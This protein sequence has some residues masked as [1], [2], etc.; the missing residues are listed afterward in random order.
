MEKKWKQ[1]ERLVAAI[2]HALNQTN[3]RIEWGDRID[4]REFD[5]T[6]RFSYF[7]YSYLTVVECKDYLVPV[8]EV[9]AFVTKARRAHANKA[10]MVSSVGFQSGAIKVARD[11]GIELFV[12]KESNKWPDWVKIIGEQPAIGIEQVALYSS[13]HCHVFPNSSSALTYYTNHTILINN[14]K[15]QTTLNEFI[16]SQRMYWEKHVSTKPTTIRLDIPPITVVDMPFVVRF[17][18][19]HV[20]FQAQ[21]INTLILETGGVDPEMVPALFSFTDIITGKEHVVSEGEIWIGFDTVIQEG[22]FYNDPLRGQNFYCEKRTGNCI[23]VVLV[24]S[25]QHGDLFQCTYDQT[26]TGPSR[27]LEVTDPNEIQRLLKMYDLYKSGSQTNDHPLD[28]FSARRNEPC[29]CGSGRKF[30][31]CHGRRLQ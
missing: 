15:Q 27:V 16:D 3:A 23:T 7:S 31:K 14:N 29:P 30:K 21:I 20:T 9:E 17:K 2:H 22:K 4:G 12:L 26:L 6:I 25:Y 5:L 19:E 24:E 10:I 13:G 1:F 18:A 8:G 11:E 28:W